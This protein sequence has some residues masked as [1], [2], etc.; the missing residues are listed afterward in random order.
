[1]ALIAA[2]P[3]TIEAVYFTNWFVA[4]RGGGRR[5]GGARNGSW[6]CL[7]RKVPRGGVIAPA[8][9]YAHAAAQDVMH[10]V[11]PA[12]LPATRGRLRQLAR[13]QGPYRCARKSRGGT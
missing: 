1:M 12:L 7:T 3:R 8:A 5:G 9:S 2:L 6:G 10:A 4:V 13:R 11:D